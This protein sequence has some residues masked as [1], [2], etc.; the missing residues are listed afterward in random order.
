MTWSK[1]ERTVAG[2]TTT[3]SV[4]PVKMSGNSERWGLVEVWVVSVS[5]SWCTLTRCWETRQHITDCGHDWRARVIV[6]CFSCS[7]GCYFHSGLV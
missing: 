6:L 3:P 5:G 2:G 7:F 4:A 1:Q